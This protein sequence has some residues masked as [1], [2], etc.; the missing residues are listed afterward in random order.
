MYNKLFG[1]LFGIL[2]SIIFFYIL[3]QRCSIVIG[4]GIIEKYNNHCIMAN[5]R[6][7]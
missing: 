1:I 4:N 3:N 2:L 7:N 5:N 6:C